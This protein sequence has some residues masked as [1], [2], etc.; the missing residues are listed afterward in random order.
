MDSVQ[1]GGGGQPQI[2]TFLNVFLVKVKYCS[3]VLGHL[4]R[5]SW[6]NPIHNQYIFY[7]NCILKTRDNKIILF[8][9]PNFRG[10]EGGVKK[11][12]D[13]IHTFVFFN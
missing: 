10:G 6:W 8:W 4:D 12:L 5:P 3:K 1:R 2:Q 7:R 11:S 9:C 13:R